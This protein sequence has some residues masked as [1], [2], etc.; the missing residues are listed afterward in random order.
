MDVSATVTSKGQVTIP[1][2]VRDALGIKDGDALIFRVEGN[3]AVIARTAHFLELAG[4]I[5]VPAAKRNIAWDDVIRRTR[6]ARAAD[7]R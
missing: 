6:S 2:P 3:R 5:R 4:T 7:R 1:K